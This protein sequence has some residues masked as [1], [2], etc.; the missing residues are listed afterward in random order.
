MEISML[1]ICA[2]GSVG[3]L[4]AKY[5]LSNVCVMQS[6]GETN[7]GSTGPPAPIESRNVHVP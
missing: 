2:D 3:V 1:T 4:T 5:V 6:L 7:C